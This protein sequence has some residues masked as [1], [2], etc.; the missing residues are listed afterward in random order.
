MIKLHKKDLRIIQE[1][2]LDARQP[3]SIIARK[4]GLSKE[5]ANYRIKQLEKKGIIR[6]YYSLYNVSLLGYNLYKI[7]IKLQN[8]SKAK[9]EEFIRYLLKI[10]QLGLIA[11]CSGNYDMEIGVVSRSLL[12]FHKILEQITNEYGAYIKS[13]D[14]TT[15]IEMRQYNRKYLYDKTPQIKEFRYFSK[16]EPESYD[17]T[18]LKI[19]EY[20]AH[21]GRKNNTDIEKALR[22]SRK[23]AGNRIK[24]M[25]KNNI[26]LGFRPLIDRDKIQMAYFRVLIKLQSM[27]EESVKKLFGY[28]K[29]SPN[30]MWINKTIGQWE[31]EVELEIEDS[32]RCHDLV[33]ELKHNFHSIIADANIIEIFKDYK[34]E[35]VIS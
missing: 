20:L 32:K 15:I 13:K 5:L 16:E 28:L 3:T 7:F 27:K 1:L 14:V 33:L 18:D 34:Y 8:I 22:I 19:L 9:E 10:K 4:T 29:M 12:E 21:N 30:V 35:F 17:D 23:V 24:K 6:G 2:D 26:I 11:T 25:L 31:L